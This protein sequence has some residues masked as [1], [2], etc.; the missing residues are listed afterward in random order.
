LRLRRSARPL[1]GNLV[2]AAVATGLVVVS[3]EIR[4]VPGLR[5]VDA[6]RW[7]PRFIPDDEYDPPDAANPTP[8]G[9]DGHPHRP[10]RRPSPKR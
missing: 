7:A 1:E 2:L 9:D 8:T 4:Y 10:S 6:R 3:L 5:V